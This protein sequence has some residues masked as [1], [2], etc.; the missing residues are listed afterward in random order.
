M[1]RSLLDQHGIRLTLRDERTIGSPIA[2]TFQGELRP[3]Q[4]QAVERV[5]RHDEGIICAPMAFGKTVV[6]AAL[7]AARKV[8]TLVLVHR[9]Q[10]LDQW[11]ERLAAFFNGRAKSRIS[12][13]ASRRRRPEKTA[14]N[15][16]T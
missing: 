8:N 4:S 10:L 1:P 14:I 2:V 13:P 12:P 3:E 5:R 9:Q 15:L 16:S 6:G 11:R 7:I